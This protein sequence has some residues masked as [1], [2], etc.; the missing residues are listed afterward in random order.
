MCNTVC[1]ITSCCA[2]ARPCET[3]GGRVVA[4]TGIVRLRIDPCW[5]DLP[6][7]DLRRIIAADCPRM[8]AGQMHDV[9]GV[10]FPGLIGLDAD[11]SRPRP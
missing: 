7:P 1:W 2:R 11:L 9:C 6:M 3:S 8:I 5:P 4:S 10:H